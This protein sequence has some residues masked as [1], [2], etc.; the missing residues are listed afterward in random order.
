MAVPRPDDLHRPVLKIAS[1]A[2]R[3][4]SRREFVEILKDYLHLTQSDLQEMV[5]SGTQSRIKNRTDWAIT[6]LKK[7]GL[8]NNPQPNQ[9]EITPEGGKFL[10][11]HQGIIRAVDLQKMWP[12]Y[13]DSPEAP[14]SSAP[15]SVDITPD[16]QMA[17]NFLEHRNMLSERVLDNVTKLEPSG[18]ERLVVELLR[19]MGYG[20]GQVVGQSGD[21]GIDGIINHD[22][23][24]LEKIYVQAK[25]YKSSQV[26]EPDIRN[27]SGSLDPQGAIKGVFITTSTFSSSAR[28][29][30]QDISKGNKFIRLIDGLELGKLMIEYGVGVFTA[31]T[32]EVKE[33]DANYF[34]E[35]DQ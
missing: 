7:A 22:I 12:D 3:P 19:K 13:Q 6:H 26:G 29:T 2:A 14:Q 11:D 34:N 25:R 4:L 35:L 17:N 9:W 30:A 27:F 32:Y 5:P 28:Q 31:V 16:E 33:L 10:D 15:E 8:L 21:Q 23:L 24:G 20:D 18:F 1:D